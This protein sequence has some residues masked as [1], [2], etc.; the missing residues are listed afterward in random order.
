MSSIFSIWYI[1]TFLQKARV[2]GQDASSFLS[3]KYSCSIDMNVVSSHLGSASASP[4]SHLSSESSE[5]SE[6]DLPSLEEM[7]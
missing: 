1:D 5:S 3:S 7:D 4:T 2:I 6:V